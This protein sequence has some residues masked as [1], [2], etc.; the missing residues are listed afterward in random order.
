MH[1]PDTAT[2]SWLTNLPHFL[3]ADLVFIEG[4]LAAILLVVIL[5]HQPRLA[6]FHWTITATLVLLLSFVFALIG[7]TVYFQPPV[8]YSGPITPAVTNSFPSHH[9]LLAAA[10]VA[11]VFLARP[12]LALP[13][14]AMSGIISLALVQDHDHHVVDVLGST[15][16]VALA[17][18]VALLVA[19]AV[20]RWLNP[21]LPARS[22]IMQPSTTGDI[23]TTVQDLRE[24]MHRV[25]RRTR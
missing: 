1:V 6:T 19:P 20:V 24:E 9:A 2:T 17:T 11:L 12:W 22:E 23:D 16:F 8:G 14:A 7:T 13:F 21:S 25:S 4:S 5:Y 3:A 15:A 18:G 10:I